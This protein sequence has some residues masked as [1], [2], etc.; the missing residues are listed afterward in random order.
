MTFAIKEI[1]SLPEG[2]V[3]LI[4]DKNG[5]AVQ[6]FLRKQY[7]EPDE[8][9]FTVTEHDY[10]DLDHLE[11]G[12]IARLLSRVHNLPLVPVIEEGFDWDDEA[13]FEIAL[14][15]LEGNLAIA[16]VGSVI[17]VGNP[18]T[19]FSDFTLALKTGVNTW[20]ESG[21]GCGT[22]ETTN[23]V[24]PVVYTPETDE[25]MEQGLEEYEGSIEVFPYLID[26]SI[27][28]A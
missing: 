2:S 27:A 12:G 23:L 7:H 26:T 6:A 19:A 14:D 28:Q 18:R 16:P 22:Y 4:R 1:G 3:G 20:L 10:G 11:E 15:H 17:L 5:N 13:E 9:T 21:C 24:V 8:P 25:E